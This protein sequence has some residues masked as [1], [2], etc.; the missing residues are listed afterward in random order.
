M[1]FAYIVNLAK[2]FHKMATTSFLKEIENKETYQD[3]IKIAEKNMKHLSSGSSRIVYQI[4]G[5]KRVIKLAKNDKG[6]AQNKAETKIKDNSKF[7]NKSKSHANN[8]SWIE[9]SFLEKIDEKEFEEMTG[10]TFK[11]FGKSIEYGLKSI[12]S[13]SSSKPKSFDEISK[14]RIYEDI[15]RIGKKYKLM[16]GD[17]SRISSWGKKDNNPVLIDTGLT[18]DVYDKYYD[19]DKS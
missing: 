12:S 19:K 18:K 6:I 15:Y 4:R 17:L 10:I 16:P 7:I 5:E 1:K 11:N 3:R 14:S 13:S 2:T 9:V 8:F